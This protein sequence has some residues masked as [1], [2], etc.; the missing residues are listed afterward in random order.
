ML[1]TLSRLFTFG[2]FDGMKTDIV[3]FAFLERVKIIA[4]TMR[5]ASQARWHRFIA[6]C[7][8]HEC[9]ECITDDTDVLDCIQVF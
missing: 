2:L 4:V 9:S 3:S 7:C 6:D 5:I 8:L 1:R